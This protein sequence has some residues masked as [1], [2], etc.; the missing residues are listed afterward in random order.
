M[1]RKK[2]IIL[3]TVSLLICILIY[4]VSSGKAS[5]AP[6]HNISSEVLILEDEQADLTLGDILRDDNQDRFK[7]NYQDLITYNIRSSAIWVKFR[8]KNQDEIDL[9]QLNN[10]NLHE[11][12]FY[13]PRPEGGFEK[14]ETGFL[15]SF[16]SREIVMDRFTF[17]LNKSSTSWHYLRIRS[18]HFL[19][20]T[21]LAGSSRIL[22]E[23]YHNRLLFFGMYTCLILAIAG[24][25]LI[26]IFFGSGIHFTYYLLYVLSIGSINLFERGFL[27]QF[28]WPELPGINY[29]FPVVPF[30]TASSF[31]LFVY[32][33]LKSDWIIRRWVWIVFWS[34][35]SILLSTVILRLALGDYLIPIVIAQFYTLSVILTIVVTALINYHSINLLSNYII[36]LLIG[37]LFLMISVVLYILAENSII[38]HVSLAEY[39]IV[40]GSTFE[41]ICFTTSVGLYQSET[42][43][44]LTEHG[45]QLAWEKRTIELELEEKNRKLVS[46]VAE[47]IKQS[48]A[49]EKLKTDLPSDEIQIKKRIQSILAT[50]NNWGTFKLYFE[51]VNPDF[52]RKL[53]IQ[54]PDLT[55]NEVRHCA[56]VK[57]GLSSKEIASLLSVTKRGVDKARERLYRK[58]EISGENE[59][60]RILNSL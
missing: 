12:T 53:Q 11:V 9:C 15:K 26:Q 42:R 36:T 60:T 39:S 28:F 50:D 5:Q 57:M 33:F 13:R 44:R 27:F 14:V 54:F 29:W 38:G 43:K 48:E 17:E 24:Y 18:G 56:F 55:P 19:N 8:V 41:I 31:L 37:L 49:L 30:F 1:N 58:L 3:V 35:T 6:F 2:I 16:D 51:N 7:P 20:T 21:I 59:L 52:F 32:H 46:F 23:R 22:Q 4:F 34:L 25:T 40:I 47:Q 10:P 45:Q